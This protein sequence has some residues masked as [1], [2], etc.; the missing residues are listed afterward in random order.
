MVE[1]GKSAFSTFK[2]FAIR[3]KTGMKHKLL[4]RERGGACDVHTQF[5]VWKCTRTCNVHEYA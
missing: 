1:G 5:W 3:F 2:T 4:L